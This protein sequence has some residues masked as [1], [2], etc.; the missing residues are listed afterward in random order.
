M[1]RDLDRS[2]ELTLPFFDAETDLLR[3]SYAPGKWTAREILGHL[4]DSELV[5]QA[6]ARFILS[7]PGCAIVPFD[8]DKW[9]RTLAYPQRKISL[10]RRLYVANRESLIELVDLLPEAIFGREGKHPEHP[11]YRAWDVATKTSTHNMHHWGQLVA[12]RDGTAWTPP[13]APAS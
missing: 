13:A 3:R 9:A 10:M 2:K 1:I 11:S 8:Q 12:I 5:F 7:E 6:R 4:T